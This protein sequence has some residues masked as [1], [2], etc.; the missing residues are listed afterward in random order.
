MNPKSQWLVHHHLVL[1][2]VSCCGWGVDDNR[3]SVAWCFAQSSGGVIH[4]DYNIGTTWDWGV[5]TSWYVALYDSQINLL[6]LMNTI[7]I[8]TESVDNNNNSSYSIDTYL[9]II[10]LSYCTQYASLLACKKRP[11]GPF[12]CLS[13]PNFK[14]RTPWPRGS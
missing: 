2:Q 12:V 13:L 14:K 9:T 10:I 6:I 5:G 3:K 1:H 4:A 11:H 8:L 7:V